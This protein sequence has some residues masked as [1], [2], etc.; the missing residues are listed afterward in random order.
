MRG[1]SRKEC[2]PGSEWNKCSAPLCPLDDYSLQHCVWYPGEEICHLEAM[3]QIDWVAHQ[4][5]L[6]KEDDTRYFTFP[7]LVKCAK[8]GIKDKGQEEP[9]GVIE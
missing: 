6:N 8:V 1:K 9:A 5:K 3:Q 4:R 2:N 7:L